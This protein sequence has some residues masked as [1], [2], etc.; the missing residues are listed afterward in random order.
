MIPQTHISIFQAL[1]DTLGDELTTSTLTKATLVHVS[2]T[3]EDFV[4]SRNLPALIFT[5]FQES[6]H[7]QQETERYRELAEVAMQVCI[8]AGKPLPADRDIGAL[9]IELEGDDPLRQEWFLAI[10]ST[11]FTA[12][13]AGLDN[14]ENVSQEAYRRFECIWSFDVELVNRVLDTLE[15]VIAHYRPDVLPRLQ[16]ARRDYPAVEPKSEVVVKFTNELLRFEDRLQYRLMEK[17]QALAM[18]EAR[19]RS[20]LENAPIALLSMDANGTLQLLEDNNERLIFSRRGIQVG[21]SL[22]EMKTRLPELQQHCD[23]A[24]AGEFVQAIIHLDE[25]VFE[26]RSTPILDPKTE[27]LTNVLF[28]FI[29][30]TARHQAEQ[31]RGEQ[32]RRLISLRKDKELNALRHQLMLTLS[33]EI[34][35]PLASIQ[36]SSDLLKNYAD[37]LSE[38]KKQSRLA[39]IQKQVERLTEIMENINTVILQDGLPFGQDVVS[40]NIN[41]VVGTTVTNLETITERPITFHPLPETMRLDLDPRLLEYILSNL[42]TNAAKYSDPGSAIDCTLTIHEQTLLIRVTDEGI[43]I[44]A[45]EI[46]QVLSPFYRA[47]NIGVVGGTGLG[48]SIVENAIKAMNGAIRIE[49]ELGEGTSVTVELPFRASK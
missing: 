42:L 20:I 6:S 12:V 4:L 17:N 29:D 27:T 45:D 49:S 25:G 37:R 19:Y 15:D 11:D 41:E 39:N 9:Q 43:G 7:W 2:H 44:P 18:S 24:L 32:E 28:I 38:A 8:F 40:V 5:G 30:I 1:K 46:E 48:F 31:E 22:D 14:M 35:T 36:S 21:A 34:R 3:L 23:Q 47:S 13:L 33:H 16:R 26:L 10:L